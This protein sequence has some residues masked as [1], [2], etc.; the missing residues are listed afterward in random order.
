MAAGEVKAID[1]AGNATVLQ[2]YDSFYKKEL[3]PVNRDLEFRHF[4]NGCGIEVMRGGSRARFRRRDGVWGDY[5][6]TD[7]AIHSMADWTPPLPCGMLS[8]VSP[9]STAASVPR[10]IGALT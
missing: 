8:A 5:S 10:T 9:V 7:R 1:P 3:I 2:G 6:G 4:C